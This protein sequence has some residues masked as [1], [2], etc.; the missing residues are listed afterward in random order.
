MQLNNQPKMETSNGSVPVEGKRAEDGEIPTAKVDNV[1]MTTLADG[2]AVA[3]MEE[4]KMANHVDEDKKGTLEDEEEEEGRMAWDNKYQYLLSQI[5]FAVGLGNVWR[6]PYLCQ[7]NGGGAFLIPYLIMLIIEGIPIFHIEFAIGQRIRKGS[8]S[9]WSAISPYLGGLGWASVAVSFFVGLYYNVIIAWCMFYLFNSF[10]SPL[11]WASCPGNGT[12]PECE[13]SSPTTFFWYRETLDITRDIEESGGL[14]WRLTL[15]LFC[16]WLIVCMAMIKGIKS[17]GKAIYFTAT[18]PYVVLLIFFF[19]GVTLEGAGD[20]LARMFTPQVDK[21]TDPI[22]W[23]EAATQVF[24]SLGVAFGGLISFSSYN[25]RKNNC[26]RDAVTVAIINSGTSI[27]ACVVIFSVLGFKATHD[28]QKCLD[29]FSAVLQRSVPEFN[30]T[31]TRGNYLD[32][33]MAYNTT[34][35]ISE[36]D[37]TTCDKT[38]NLDT[39]V[40][41]TG[42]AFIVFTE[43]MNQFYPIAL[44]PLW[45]ILFF[46]ML[47]NLGLSSMFGTLEGVLTPILDSGVWKWRKEFLVVTLCVVSFLTGLIFTQKSGN[48]WLDIF[49][50]YSG[51]FPLLLIGFIELIA[52]IWIYGFNRLSDDLLYMTGS[53]PNMYWKVTWL[54]LSPLSMGVIFAATIYREASSFPATYQSWDQIKGRLG[55]EEP[56]PWYAMMACY[57][58]VVLPLICIPIVAIKR[59]F[60]PYDGEVI[61][62]IEGA[63]WNPFRKHEPKKSDI[64]SSG[65]DGIVNPAVTEL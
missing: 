47:L 44:G 38:K 9:V 36:F 56:Y 55:E 39:A 50:D 4:G 57:L 40:E 1:E 26:T 12:V 53:R 7:R 17:S 29:E 35:A 43:A 10:Q 34:P 65:V 54:F 48:Y 23:L 46:L 64:S 63:R 16:A 42:L 28:S 31:I 61:Q 3:D 8:I 6:F 58:L 11:P 15:C 62:P 14:D 5:G 27:F 18:F 21:L 25:P 51:T 60:V 30:D 19:R 24:F 49:N 20:G 45:S 59:I 37:F 52:V 33:Q 22:V 13:A 41:G 32:F 2:K